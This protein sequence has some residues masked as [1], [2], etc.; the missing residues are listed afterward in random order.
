MTLYML[1]VHLQSFLSITI[2][3]NCQILSC[4]TLVANERYV[5][6]EL[7]FIVQSR[8]LCSCSVFMYNSTVM[9]SITKC[10]ERILT[11]SQSWDQNGFGRNYVSQSVNFLNMF[12]WIVFAVRY[13]LCHASYVYFSFSTAVSPSMPSVPSYLQHPGNALL[14][15]VSVSF[16]DVFHGFFLFFSTDY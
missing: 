2:T 7:W 15:T 14:A 13:V 10:S 8:H 4:D 3:Q 12:S 6:L 16:M 11:V 5:L 1:K 9:C